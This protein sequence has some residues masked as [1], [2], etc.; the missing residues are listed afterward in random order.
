MSYWNAL[1]VS[2]SLRL[3]RLQPALR[4]RE[5]VVAEVDLLRSP[6]STRTSGSRRSSRSGT[7]SSRSGP[8]PRPTACAR[9]PASLAAASSLPAT[10]NTASPGL[11]AA[12]RQRRL[13][14]ALGREELGDR[15][16]CAPP[17]RAIDVAEAGRRPRCAPTRS[18]CR[19]SCAAVAAAPGAGIARTT[20][21]PSTMPANRP[22]PEPAKMLAR[23]RRSASGLRRSGLSVPY[24]SIASA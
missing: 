21:P 11:D 3:E 6:R 18:A 15:A 5:R 9:T 4:H 22:K 10:K 24:F 17:L 16:P 14:H 19:R 23:R 7:R 8:A 13:V 1:I 2:G 12:L 20:P